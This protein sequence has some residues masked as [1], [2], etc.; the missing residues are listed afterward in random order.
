MCSDEGGP[1]EEYKDASTNV[2]IYGDFRFKQL[3]LFFALTLG[4]L[5]VIFRL[6]PPLEGLPR[7]SLKIIGLVITFVFWRIEE[8]STRQWKHYIDRAMKLEKKLIYEQ[9]LSRYP[10]NPINNPG[11]V[12]FVQYFKKFLKTFFIEGLKKICTH[13]KSILKGQH[14]IRYLKTVFTNDRIAVSTHLRSIIN[15]QHSTRYVKTHLFNATNS[16]RTIFLL[17]FIF[18]GASI[19]LQL[20]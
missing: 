16:V 15:K 4:F 9:Y 12:W 11:K 7:L 14:S 13:S 20:Q 17:M 19:I 8:S 10:D 5:T 3:T 1:I 18:W 2:R 6:E